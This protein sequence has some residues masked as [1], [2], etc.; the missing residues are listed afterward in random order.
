MAHSILPP[1]SKKAVRPERM[2]A[3]DRAARRMLLQLLDRLCL[4]KIT[5]MEGDRTHTFGSR[6]DAFP[7]EAEVTV[8]HPRFYRSAVFG[9]SVGSA[10]AYIN[11]YWTADDLTTLIRILTLNQ[12]VFNRMEKGLARLAAP[13]RRLLHFLNRNTR[14]GSRENIL[15]HYDLGEEFYKLFLDE[16]LTYSCGI[17]ETEDSSLKQ[18]SIAKYDRICRKLRLGRKDHVLEIGTGWGGFAIHAAAHYGCRVTTTTISD[19]QHQVA[20]RRFADAGLTDK[21]TLLKRDYRDLTGRFDKL[22][23]IEMIEAVGHENLGAYFRACA[24][25][26]RPDGVMAL[27]AITIGDEEYERALRSVD[28]VKRYVFPGGH[29]PSVRVM[30]EVA[31]GAGAL[32]VVHLEEMTPHYAETLRRWR[33]RF[34]ESRARVRELGYDEPFLRLWEF[35]L[36]YCEGAFHERHVGSVQLLLAR[37]GW[38]DALPGGTRPALAQRAST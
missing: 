19:N 30:A 34:L 10:Q 23:S 38:R 15:V 21:I 3:A 25:R 20:A 22:V 28:F 16:T 14:R 18:A 6:S 26:L 9:G 1:E 12:A 33:E 27:Q 31:S 29:L 2:Q 4:G 24:E 8:H 36:A 32:R 7:L 11:G 13:T 35:Y 37:R 17:F 5:V